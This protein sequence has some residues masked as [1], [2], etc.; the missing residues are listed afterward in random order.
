MVLAASAVQSFSTA[1]ENGL[2]RSNWLKRGTHR[3]LRNELGRPLAAVRA[4][5][6]T[7]RSPTAADPAFWGTWG[8]VVT[9]LAS[10]A[11]VLGR[12]PNSPPNCAHDRH[13]DVV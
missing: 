8:A 12:R 10:R 6:S 13:R 3:W 7:Y 4:W 9:F 1:L 5:S 11:L 2:G